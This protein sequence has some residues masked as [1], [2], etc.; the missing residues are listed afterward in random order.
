MQQHYD[1]NFL[2]FTGEEAAVIK[3]CVSTLWDRILADPDTPAENLSRYLPM[4]FRLATEVQ[5][6]YRF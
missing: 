2:Y 5:E 4:I 3:G 6:T 1:Q